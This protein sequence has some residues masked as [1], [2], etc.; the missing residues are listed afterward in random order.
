M[1]NKLFTAIIAVALL[2]L[3]YLASCTK[4]E[5]AK[6]TTTIGMATINGEARANLD[7][8]NDTNQYGL[9][10]V[11][12]EKVPGGTQI[13]AR[14]NTMDLDPNPS[15]NVDYRDITFN[16][17][18]TSSGLYEVEV[19]AGPSS[20]SVMLIADQFKYNQKI[21][22]STWEEKI[23]SMSDVSLSVINDQKR[24]RNLTFFPEN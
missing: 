10:E 20:T 17:T 1:K 12:Y 8:T 11:Q 19:Y 13:F 22:D 24:I 18:V 4:I 23:F 9:Y 3:F 6:S 2:G 21:N 7:L 16:T 14:I 15:G 5:D